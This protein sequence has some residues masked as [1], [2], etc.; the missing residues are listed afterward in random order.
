M[1]DIK[2]FSQDSFNAMNHPLDYGYLDTPFG[3]ALIASISDRLCTLS[4]EPDQALA[5]KKLQKRF[6]IPIREHPKK[7][8]EWWNKVLNCIE[9]EIDFPPL[10][11]KGSPFQCAVWQALLGIE[12]GTTLSY[13]AIA[14]TIRKPK[15]VRAVGQA[16]GANPL[17][18][19]IPCHRVIQ[20]NGKLG[21]FAYGIA[22]K[23][24][25][26]A[27]ER[28]PRQALFSKTAPSEFGASG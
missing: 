9:G 5:L 14:E 15:A 13:Q 2:I 21:G 6:L 1:H 17:A 27:L 22:F 16:V 23:K 18:I 12:R 10:L 20:K 19:I 26:L 8:K 11:L 3:T 25:L 7:V 24:R 28:E 4:F